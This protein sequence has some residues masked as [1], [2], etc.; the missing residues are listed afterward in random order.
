MLPG[1]PTSY[2]MES[3]P[4]TSYPSLTEDIEVDVAVLGAGIAGIST[5]W[6]V[7]ATGRSVALL[8]AGRIAS[9]V[10]GHTTAKLSSLHTLAY[11][12]ISR[13][14]GAEAA[15]LYAESQQSAVERAATIAG[16][17]GV[18]CDLERLPGF[19]YAATEAAVSRVRAEADAARAAGLDASYVTD[20]GLP[21]AVAGAVRVEHQAQF[22]PRKYLLGLAADLVARGGRIFE[23]TRAVGLRERPQCRVTTEQGRTVMARDVV[24]A[25]HYPVFNRALLFARLRTRR[26]LVVAGPVPAPDDPAGIYIT[27]EENT[28]S[29]RTA[30][31]RDGQRLL[32]VT[33]EH[34]TPGDADVAERWER[35]A[36]WARDRF[37]SADLTYRWAT[38]DAT[39][40]DRIPFVGPFHPGTQHVHVATGFGGWGM[41]TGVMAG[42][43]IAATIAGQHLPWT[44]LYDPRRFHPLREAGALAG[45]QGHVVRHFVGDRIRPSRVRST[46]DLAPGT[47]AVMRVGR[48]QLAVYR[49]PTGGLQSLPARCSHLGCIV[50]FNAAETAWECPCH[51]SRFDVDGTVIQGPANRALRR[52]DTPH[53]QPPDRA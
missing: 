45:L 30:P 35:L 18:D 26:E 49:D 13:T 15:R 41:S 20:T 23:G 31:Y 29:V 36:A 39:A 25:T 33:G 40:S 46:S 53:R 38:Q 42:H 50:H 10:T 14:A 7:A 17:L 3:T 34:F 21:F 16:Q 37:P 9:G 2:W 11:S 27:P 28:R 51:G 1:A 5:A 47:G 24:V 48:R 8:E 44:G 19:A 22:H 43:L 4:T 12:R 32:I 6:E 52:V